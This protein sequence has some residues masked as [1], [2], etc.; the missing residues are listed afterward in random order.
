[1]RVIGK[2]LSDDV[3]EEDASSEKLDNSNADVVE[4]SFK[5]VLSKS[6]KKVKAEKKD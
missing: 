2:F 6:Q 1:M 3:P 4:D 5:L